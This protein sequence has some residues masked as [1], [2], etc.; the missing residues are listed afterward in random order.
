MHSPSKSARTVASRSIFC[1]RSR[2]PR[3][4]SSVPRFRH[5]YSLASATARARIVSPVASAPRNSRSRPRPQDGS[6]APVSSLGS[7]RWRSRRSTKALAPSRV[8]V[9]GARPR[10]NAKGMSSASVGNVS[11]IRKETSPAYV[12]GSIAA[13]RSTGSRAASC[14]SATPHPARHS[15]TAQTEALTAISIAVM[16][17]TSRLPFKSP[18]DR[19]TLRGDSQSLLRHVTLASSMRHHRRPWVLSRHAIA[20]HTRRSYPQGP[21]RADRATFHDAALRK[22]FRSSATGLG[23]TRSSESFGRMSRKV[24]IAVTAH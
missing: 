6:N 1:V 22:P 14:S 20:T 16:R 15:G 5:L 11:A 9:C 17:I 12:D 24:H 23:L 10:Y 18:H 4:S 19:K 2:V 3:R 8:P 21:L 7:A 13:A